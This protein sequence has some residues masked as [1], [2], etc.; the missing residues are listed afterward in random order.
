MDIYGKKR[1]KTIQQ[2]KQEH[3]DFLCSYP[4]QQT[5]KR[6]SNNSIQQ[7]QL[8]KQPLYITENNNGDVVVSDNKNAVVVTDCREKHRF[9]YIGHPPGSGLSPRGICTDSLS[10][11]LV[12]DTNTKTV[13]MINRIQ[14]RTGSFY[15]IY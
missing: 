8:F 7:K 6:N 2:G 10:H 13:H 15:H 3:D 12:V 9:N 1:A 5:W 14:H 11:I 4:V